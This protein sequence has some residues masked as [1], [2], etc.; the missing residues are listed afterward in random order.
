VLRE[1]EGETPTMT[2][3]GH[4]FLLGSKVFYADVRFG[5]NSEVRM[6]NREVGFA[7]N[8]GHRQPSRAGPKSARSG[9]SRPVRIL[10]SRSDGPN[11]W[12]STKR[13]RVVFA[14]CRC[15]R[16]PHAGHD[17]HSGSDFRDSPRPPH[18]GSPAFRRASTNLAKTSGRNGPIRSFKLETRNSGSSLRAR[19]I[20]FRASSGR[21][22]RA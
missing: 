18:S 2:A 4:L 16:R 9:S 17:D 19:A 1:T 6:L 7:L 3:L 10:A 11:T 12:Y 20:H 8:N 15:L 21:P 22:A 5:S 14:Y 13:R